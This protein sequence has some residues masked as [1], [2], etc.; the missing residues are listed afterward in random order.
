MNQEVAVAEISAILK[1]SPALGKPKFVHTG[2]EAMGNVNS[3]DIGFVPAQEGTWLLGK[4][5]GQDEVVVMKGDL[6]VPDAERNAVGRPPTSLSAPI[7]PAAFARRAITV[8]KKVQPLIWRFSD[9]YFRE[10][11]SGLYFQ[12]SR[13]DRR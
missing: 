1:A 3:A 7:S 10:S 11:M 9:P 6:L 5:P 8:A 12:S 13:S 4:G 2:Q